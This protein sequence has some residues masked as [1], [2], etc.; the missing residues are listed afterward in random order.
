[1][2]CDVKT[3]N[4]LV[5]KDLNVK[6][7]DLGEARSSERSLDSDGDIGTGTEERVFPANINWSAPEVLCASI[8]PG[9]DCG[10]GPNG[11]N[12]PY[13]PKSISPSADI[14][15]LGMVIAEILTGEVPFDNPEWRRLSLDE[16]LLA[17]RKGKRPLLPRHIHSRFPWLVDLINRAWEY[18]GGDRCD[19]IEMVNEFDKYSEHY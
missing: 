8:E 10:L 11:P 2:H 9:P 18:E 15:S 7:A 17:L 12:G 16:F 19:S 4:F 3:L 6:L 14:W 13:G 5:D 1:M